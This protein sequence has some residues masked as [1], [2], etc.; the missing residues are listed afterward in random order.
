MNLVCNS[1]RLNG[2][3]ATQIQ[4]CKYF[5]KFT[6]KLNLFN[7]NEASVNVRTS[8]RSSVYSGFPATSYALNWHPSIVGMRLHSRLQ[9]EGA[10]SGSRPD[11]SPIYSARLMNPRSY[12]STSPIHSGGVVE[13]KL[14]LNISTVS[15]FR[16]MLH[17]VRQHLANSC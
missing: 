16:E 9:S 13:A 7:T 3:F 1:Y 10:L 17:I 5:A 6:S 8:R 11:P 12:T 15:S 4:Y 2:R 14:L